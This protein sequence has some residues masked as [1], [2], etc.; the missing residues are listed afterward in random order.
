MGTY[1]LVCCPIYVTPGIQLC[2]TLGPQ[3]GERFCPTQRTWNWSRVCGDMCY[4][5]SNSYCHLTVSQF[6]FGECGALSIVNISEIF[7]NWL[8]DVHKLIQERICQT[9]SLQKDDNGEECLGSQFKKKVWI[10]REESQWAKKRNS[11]LE[12]MDA[13]FFLQLDRRMILIK[14]FPPL[15][16]NQIRGNELS[17]KQS[18]FWLDIKENFLQELWKDPLKRSWILQLWTSSKQK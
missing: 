17:L 8:I 13:S 18:S 3:L 10:Q 11:P 16:K 5:L 12:S 6:P 1:S 9:L 14:V 7:K 15:M 2:P 4:H